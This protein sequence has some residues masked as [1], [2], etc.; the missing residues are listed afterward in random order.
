MPKI[1]LTVEVSAFTPRRSNSLHG[2]VTITIPEIH[3]RI[4]D[5][6]V[7]ESH[8]KRRIGLPGKPQIDR[9]GTVRKNERGKV[10]YTPV[11]QFTDK[12]TLDAFSARVIAA[13][14][15]FAPAAFEEEVV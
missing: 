4:S 13:L 11:L 9:D 10:A 15:E 1:K 8:G 14:L 6:T 3:L 2:F 7:H 5:I 12:A